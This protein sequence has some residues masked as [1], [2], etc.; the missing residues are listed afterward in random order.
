L[1][2]A[3]LERCGTRKQKGP[4][5]VM[6]WMLK[7]NLRHSDRQISFRLRREIS[8]RTKKWHFLV[9]RSITHYILLSAVN[10]HG[11]NPHTCNPKHHSA[12]L[13]MFFLESENN[14][15][16]IPG[17]VEPC[18]LIRAPAHLKHS[19]IIV[20]PY[21]T[22]RQTFHQTPAHCNG[23]RREPKV[24]GRYRVQDTEIL[25]AKGRGCRDTGCKNVGATTI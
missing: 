7:K 9:S 13:Q 17:H 8:A 4:A 18:C 16:R 12:L 24:L 2:R 21:N 1:P 15:T 20:I 3:A 5:G 19:K 23:V 10:P 25:G 6:L 22:K 11:V 14:Q